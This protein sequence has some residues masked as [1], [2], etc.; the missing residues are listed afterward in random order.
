MYS[1]LSIL[2]ILDQWTV[3]NNAEESAYN[4]TELLYFFVWI[5]FLKCVL[6]H[7]KNTWYNEKGVKIGKYVEIMT[8]AR[9]LHLTFDFYSNL[10]GWVAPGSWGWSQGV[11]LLLHTLS[12]VVLYFWSFHSKVYGPRH[13]KKKSTKF[14]IEQNKCVVFRK[15][16][17]VYV[18]TS[19]IVSQNS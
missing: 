11:S 3:S 16:Y 14:C 4:K 5:P 10:G 17:L 13:L 8:L 12:V 1:F 18:N 7:W 19:R 6:V 9:S 15:E 2:V